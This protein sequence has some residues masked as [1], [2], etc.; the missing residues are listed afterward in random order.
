MKPG[1]LLNSRSLLTYLP[2]LLVVLLG[3]LYIK[4]TWNQIKKDTTEETLQIARSIEAILPREGLDSLHLSPQ[5]LNNPYYQN[6]KDLLAQTIRVNPKA[7]F[8]YLYTEKNGN[9]VFI[10]DSE[11]A[12]S[13]DYSPPGQIFTEAAVTDW[14]PFREG[15]EVVTEPLQDRWG[16]WISALVP[17]KD[18]RSGKIIA[19]FGMDFDASAYQHAILVEGIRSAAIV[20]LF[21]L[22]LFF[23]FRVR[24]K[25]A[26]L[27]AEIKIRMEAERTIQQQNEELVELNATKDKFFSIIAH[28]LRGPFAG[29]LGLT[30]MLAATLHTMSH[31]QI[32]K[33]A[34]SMEKSSKNLYRLLE[35][36]L[37]WSLVQR[38]VINFDPKLINLSELVNE[39]TVTAVEA[40]KTKNIGLHTMIPDVL[41]VYAD[42]Q[43]LTAIIRNLV[44]NAIKYTPSGGDISVV[45]DN[46]AKNETRISI[47]DTGIGM[48]AD[49][50]NNLFKLDSMSNR[51]GTE[52]EPS[53]GLGLIICRDFVEKHHGRLWVESQEGKGSTFI[54]ALPKTEAA[55]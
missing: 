49:M 29:F 1:N 19:V 52:G 25:K 3:L 17:L 38:N 24:Q 54:L 18:S 47:K 34:N 55:Q 21:L 48:S 2:F 42:A 11:P 37:Q 35:N 22:A 31:E 26:L 20:L 46:S 8:S 33:F 40:A 12:D 7:Q 10:A 15:I 5:D 13:E 9:I 53:T 50:I 32:Q 28:D 30:E 16:T 4:H 41:K 14:L 43:M 6:L 51:K 39:S 36:L 45:A 23:F 44:S 27:E